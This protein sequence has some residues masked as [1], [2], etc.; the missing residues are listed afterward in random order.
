MEGRLSSR[1]LVGEAERLATTTASSLKP[2]FDVESL[3]EAARRGD[4]LG[5]A[6][7]AF[8]ARA[9]AVCVAGLTTVVDLELVLLGGGIGDNGGDLLLPEVR[10]AT[11]QLVPVPPEIRCAALGDR[12]VDVG[13]VGVGV[14]LA[15]E[16][17]V[18]RLVGGETVAAKR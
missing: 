10:V 13:A 3:F 14:E 11:A 15:R 16:A 12:A 1:A 2:P 17:V 4:A 18:R 7:V 5:R 9:T 8:A 6:V